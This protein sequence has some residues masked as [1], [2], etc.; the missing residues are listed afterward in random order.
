MSIILLNVLIA[1][2]SKA[3][4][5]AI[6]K[7]RRNFL[8]AR[9]NIAAL[10]GAMGLT[11][12]NTANVTMHGW[13]KTVQEKFEDRYP[14]IYGKLMYSREKKCLRKRSVFSNSDDNNS[15]DE[16]DSASKSRMEIKEE[17]Q[18]LSDHFI[19]YSKNI[20]NKQSHM[21][22]EIRKGIKD[23]HSLRNASIGQDVAVRM[24]KAIEGLEFLLMN[25][26]NKHIQQNLGEN[27]Q[28]L[29]ADAPNGS[30]ELHSKLEHSDCSP[31]GDSASSDESENESEAIHLND[32]STPWR[33]DN[34]GT[35]NSQQTSKFI[36]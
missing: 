20:D 26:D 34:V 6:S 7:G 33:I 32:L 2:V 8:S 29:P 18:R 21:M 23:M 4:D 25:Y 22:E 27:D 24:N 1:I 16:E 31:D 30:R 5:N 17:M 13:R 9:L 15:S 12:E 36:E 28:Q 14:S 10:Y 11:K 35:A 19:L 3:Y